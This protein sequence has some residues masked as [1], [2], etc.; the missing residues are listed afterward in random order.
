MNPRKLSRAELVD[1][2][3]NTVTAVAQ[4]RVTGLSP[5]QEAEIVD[6]LTSATD[7]LASANTEQVK[8]R[9]SYLEG[10]DIARKRETEVIML[11]SLLKST[12]RG[13]DAPDDQYDAVGFDA[14]APHAAVVPQA[15]TGLAV[16]R[17]ADSSILLV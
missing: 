3:E 11:L 4:H 6:T 14:P 15:P 13:V 2:A 17:F 12:M 16:R 8:R 5:E 10:N 7:S 1:F 9:A